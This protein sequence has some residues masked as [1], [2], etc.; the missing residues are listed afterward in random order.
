MEYDHVKV[1]GY[2]AIV[3]YVKVPKTKDNYFTMCMYTEPEHTEGRFEYKVMASMP[4]QLMAVGE[5]EWSHYSALKTINQYGGILLPA[6]FEGFIKLPVTSMLPNT[7]SDDTVFSQINYYFSY[8]GSGDDSVLVGPVFGVTKDND[9]GPGKTILTSLPAKTTVKS[10]YAIEKGDIY[11]NK[12]TLYW[13][14]FPE[15]DH[16][17][18]EAYAIE[19]SDEGTVY[20]LVASAMTFTTS[21]TILGL[22]PDTK[23]AVL[24]KAYDE[25]D[26]LLAIYDYTTFTTANEE[27][28]MVA[29]IS[30]EYEFD[31]VYYPTSA[32]ANEKGIGAGAIAAI[33]CGSAVIVA[34]G[35]ILV[36]L[37][38]KKRRGKTK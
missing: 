26:K 17:V 12:V 38:A 32:K 25:K 21:A 29:G 27:P 22:E 10:I 19:T 34:A 23:Y 37:L 33:A 13:Q 8:I 11:R 15:A 3:V 2:S 18:A 35:A 1:G 7:V 9:K 4:Y 36:I 31:K 20:R 14:S 24:V 6:G 5:T 30:D 28:Y 16:Y